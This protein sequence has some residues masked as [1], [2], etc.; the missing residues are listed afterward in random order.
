MEYTSELI[1]NLFDIE[2]FNNTD[3]TNEIINLFDTYKLN[4]NIIINNLE[5]IKCFEKFNK[6]NFKFNIKSFFCKQYNITFSNKFLNCFNFLSIYNNNDIKIIKLVE[7]YIFADYLLISKAYTTN[8]TYFLMSCL[9]S[10]SR[11]WIEL[12]LSHVFINIIDNFFNNK[13]MELLFL[14]FNFFLFKNYH[15]SI[16][17]LYNKYNKYLNHPSKKTHLLDYYFYF[18]HTTITI[19][20]KQKKGKYN[21][22]KSD[23]NYMFYKSQF[24]NNIYNK[25]IYK[26]KPIKYFLNQF[27]KLLD[28]KFNY[29]NI[30]DKYAIDNIISLFNFNNVEFS[31]SYINYILIATG[32]I[33]SKL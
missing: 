27:I 4:N 19:I 28:F 22:D 2:N 31:F 11:N 17:L 1:N 9:T 20:D 24:I 16:K 25:L 15:D 13:I 10:Y 33:Y 12:N 18:D 8:I 6:L 32:N 26:L 7:F 29:Y 5:V 23:P 14:D 30:D 21:I 3:Y